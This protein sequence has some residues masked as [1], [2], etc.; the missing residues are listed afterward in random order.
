MKRIVALGGELA[1]DHNEILHAAHLG[2]EDDFVAAE[3]VAFSG[4][5]GQETAGDDGVHGNFHGVERLRQERIFVHH[6][7]EQRTIERA[8]VDADAHRAIVL[9]GHFDHGTEVVVV[10]FADIDVAGINTVLGKRAGAIGIL[11]E[12]QVAVVVEVADDGDADTEF[13]ERFDYFRDGFG[14]GFR[15]DGDAHQ[16]RTRLSEGHNLIDRRGGVGGVGIGHGLDHDG[17]ISAHPDI[18]DSNGHRSA[19]GK[20]SHWASVKPTL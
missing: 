4:L 14:G 1:I 9:N 11:L 7:R 8:P 12:K 19:P 6:A 18:A 10:F 13:I 2:A 17:V 15:V 20:C 16:L 5:G 3:P